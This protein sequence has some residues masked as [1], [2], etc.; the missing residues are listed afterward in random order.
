MPKGHT[1]HDRDQAL[2]R[3]GLCER[4][5]NIHATARHILTLPPIGSLYAIIQLVEILSVFN[6]KY[7][8]KG[9][10]AA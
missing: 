8:D 5:L 2:A 7:A 3:R 9:L 6:E 10:P 1:K 4:L